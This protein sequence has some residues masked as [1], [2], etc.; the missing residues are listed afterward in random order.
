MVTAAMD[1]RP[2]TGNADRNALLALV[3]LV[4][5]GIVTGFGADSFEHVR[6]HGLDYPLIVHVHAVLFTSWLV[7]FT[8][9]IAL[10]RNRRP[11]LHQRLGIAGALLAAGMVVLGPATALQIAAAN[12]DGQ[13][14]APEFLAVE[15]IT[16]LAFAVFT[17]AGLLLRRTPAAHKRLMLLGLIYLSTPGF[18]RYLNGL[19]ANSMGLLPALGFGSLGLFVRIYLG[20]DILIVGLGIY[21]LVTRRRLFPV[22]LAGVAFAALLQY[23]ALMLLQIPAWKTLSVK[24]ISP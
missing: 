24:L 1:G 2:A 9:Q 21:D 15:F 18:A 7:L 8:V 12:F 10:V 6:R 20:P 11:D 13:G 22:Y 4:W 3:A 14:D 5:V 17:G 19:I 16:V 23:T